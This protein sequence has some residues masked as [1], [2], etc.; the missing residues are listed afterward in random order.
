M[1]HFCDVKQPNGAQKSFRLHLFSA[2][3]DAVVRLSHSLSERLK[4]M[5]I[6]EHSRRVINSLSSWIL[7]SRQQINFG[8][9]SAMGA[10]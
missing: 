7:N 4:K 9:L 2:H 6:A 8:W 5:K 1:Y 10:Y 3:S